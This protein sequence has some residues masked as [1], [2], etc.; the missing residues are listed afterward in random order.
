[1]FTSSITYKLALT[2][3]LTIL[4]FSISSVLCIAGETSEKKHLRTYLLLGQSNMVGWGD[5]SALDPKWAKAQEVNARIHFCSKETGWKVSRLQPSRRTT[6]KPYKVK[7]TFGPEYSFVDSISK[8]HKNED[9]LFLK[10]AVGGTTLFAAWN[11][12]WTLANARKVKEDRMEGKLRLYAALLQKIQVLQ[13]YARENGYT[14]IDI[15]SVVW[16]QGESDAIRAFTAKTYKANL[17]QF[18]RNLRADL[19][20]ADFRFIYLQVNSMKFPHID[21]VRKAQVELAH[22]LKNTFVVKSSPVNRPEDFPKYDA[23]HYNKDGVINIGKALA[24]K[25]E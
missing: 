16:V 7:G 3:T 5:Y 6:D 14:G 1:M 17:T 22:E 25:S 9:I 19:P 23:V 13:K 18:I 15:Q 11:K 8:K 20:D 24:E 4:L 10:H 21:A 12:E 2:Q